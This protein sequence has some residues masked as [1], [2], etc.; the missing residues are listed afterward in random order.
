MTSNAHIIWNG[1][2]SFGLVNIPVALHLA[3]KESG[4]NFDWLDKR[5]MDLVGYKRINKRTGQEIEKENIVKG[6]AYEKGQYVILTD[7]EIKHALIKS[8]Q[9]IELESFV[10]AADIPLEYFERPY[11]LAPTSK[12]DKAYALLRETLL[13]TRRVGIARVVIHNKQH[14]AAIVPDGLALVLI[15]MRWA[16]QIRPWGEL[17]LPSRRIEGLTEREISMAEQ[18]VEAMSETWNPEKLKD[19]FMDE[20]MEMVEEKVKTGHIESAIEYEFEPASTVSAEVIDFTELLQKSLHRK[21]SGLTEK[22][23]ARSTS[24]SKRAGAKKVF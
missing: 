6:I 14:A 18:L 8:T 10:S 12:S 22:T 3:T 11:Y 19:S 9:T 2:I 16:H 15:L 17:E 13:K 20:V 24:A 1:S 7:E 4:L 21:N 23:E 5:T